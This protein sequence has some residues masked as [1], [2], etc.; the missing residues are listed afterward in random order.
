MTDRPTHR[1]LVCAPLLASLAAGPVFLTAI[2]L[3][4][5]P[6]AQ[7]WINGF[8]ALLLFPVTIPFGFAVALIPT[9]VGTLALYSLGRVAAIFRW[10]PF[11]GSAG[12]LLGWAMIAPSNQIADDNWP[13]LIT[14]AACALV[15]RARVDWP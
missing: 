7:G 3:A 10:W 4:D 8:A 9:I 15:C 1:G 11:W 12:A 13:W 14:G 6:S 5:A 2:A